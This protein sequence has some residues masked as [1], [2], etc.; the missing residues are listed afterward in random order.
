[1]TLNFWYT[2]EALPYTKSV[3][4]KTSLFETNALCEGLEIKKEKKKIKSGAPQPKKAHCSFSLAAS[5]LTSSPVQTSHSINIQS[6]LNFRETMRFLSG[7]QNIPNKIAW[8]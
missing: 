7:K 5:D 6:V 8:P 1:M 3:L 4:M 2:A